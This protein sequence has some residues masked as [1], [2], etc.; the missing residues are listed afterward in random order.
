[1]TF[2]DLKTIPA[3]AQMSKVVAEVRDFDGRDCLWVALPPDIRETGLPDVDYIDTENFVILPIDFST[4]TLEVDIYTTLAHDAQPEDRGFSGLA[5]HI[6]DDLK[7]FE[8][9]YIRGTN[10]LKENPPAP[11]NARGIQY[12]AFPDAKFDFLRE[13][14]PGV[15]EA[16]ANLGLNE[17]IK[18]KL[19][20]TEDVVTSYV[21][22]EKVLEVEGSLCKSKSGKVGLRV[23]IGTE[24]YF[25]DLRVTHTN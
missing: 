8:S 14:F 18:L 12:F 17:W 13:N 10:G 25:S 11:R 2:Y 19:E 7:N 1:M 4:G 24:A 16:P 3:G 22:G 6:D 5:Y 15:Y 20:V 9:V 23:D 21:N